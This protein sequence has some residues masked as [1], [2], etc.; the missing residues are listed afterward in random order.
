MANANS[1]K[2]SVTV[3]KKNNKYIS[4]ITSNA[5]TNN[6]SNTSS[7]KR[8]TATSGKSQVKKTSKEKII[9][10]SRDSS[11]KEN[12]VVTPE[13]KVQKK[14]TTKEVKN[15]PKSVRVVK[16]SKN[17]RGKDENKFI[18]VDTVIDDYVIVDDEKNKEEIDADLS[19]IE[20]LKKDNEN[21]KEYV[22][23]HQEDVRGSVKDDVVVDYETNDSNEEDIYNDESSIDE[24]ISYED[25]KEDSNTSEDEDI[26]YEDN[27]ED[28]NT[29]EDEDISY[30]DNKED[31]NT[32]EDEKTKDIFQ[33]TI[34]GKEI[35]FIDSK[36]FYKKNRRKEIDDTNIS[37]YRLKRLEKEMRSLYDK[38]NDVV[39]EI[40][41]TEEINGITDKVEEVKKKNRLREI[42]TTY[43][44]SKVVVAFIIF[45]TVLFLILFGLFI[46]LV[47]YVC[48]Y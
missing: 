47:I 9:V 16:N 1:K 13:R 2:R 26:S 30:E 28:S 25:N 17:I 48:T 40:D 42:P 14:K 34:I 18:E 29:S 37:Q 11:L 33:T 46:W 12:V 3:K 21:S 44:S 23:K 36:D 38:V 24:D 43:K 32:S 31:S 10:S 27:K 19:L 22:G 35:T 41:Y 39:D 45:L 5:K 20:T 8:S 7:K 6:K 4:K 15:K